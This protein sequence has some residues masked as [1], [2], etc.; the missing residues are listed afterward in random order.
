[1]PDRRPEANDRLLDYD[2]VY[3]DDWEPAPDEETLPAR[4]R[5]KLVTPVTAALAA[6]LVAAAG[7]IGGVKVQKHQD[8]G[9]ASS[10]TPSAFTAGN[11]SG[12]AG[13]AGG[14]RGGF[15]GRG[16]GGQA[17]G[18]ATV[19][20]VTNKHGSTLYVKDGDGNTVRV[21]TTSHSKINRTA[22]TTSGA[23]H[24]G[25]TVIVQGTKSSSGTI[26]ATQVNATAAGATSGLAGLFGGGGFGGG[27][28]G[29]SQSGAAPSA[30]TQG[31]DGG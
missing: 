30:P 17:Q 20:S 3:E 22:S 31:A 26:K 13:G 19:G 28:G 24:P 29:A 4:P 10:G 27:G 7:F 16:G 8:A 9:S 11:A 1:M 15:P 18:N 12:A 14:T 2:D 6:V 5:R 21:K 23:I 25:D